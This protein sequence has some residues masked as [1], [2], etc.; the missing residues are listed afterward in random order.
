MCEPA[1]VWVCPDGKKSLFLV[2]PAQ[3]GCNEQEQ[4]VSA[5]LPPWVWPQLPGELP[6]CA[7]SLLSASSKRRLEN[8]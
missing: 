6:H 2:P 5:P 8:C 7:C 3:E 1:R 4:R